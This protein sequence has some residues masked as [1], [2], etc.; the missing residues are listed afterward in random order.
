M[1][2]PRPYLLA[3]AIA[4]RRLER[5]LRKSPEEM[6]GEQDLLLANALSA[7]RHAPFWRDRLDAGSA[8]ITHK[9]EWRE[10]PEADRV[11]APPPR[12]IRTIHTSGSTGEPIRVLYPPRGAWLQGVLHL[13]MVHHQGVAPWNPR[14]SASVERRDVGHGFVG[15]IRDHL[16]VTLPVGARATEMLSALRK[17][18]P[19]AISGTSQVL[20]EVGEALEGRYRPAT[21]LT[22][23]DTL[24]VDNRAA[25]RELF[26]VEPVDSYGTAECGMV[27]WQCSR[28]DLYHLNHEAVVVEVVDDNG[29]SVG[30][31]ED[32][33]VVLTSLWNPLMP[34]VRYL[35]GDTAA[36]ATRPCRCGSLLPALSHVTGRTFSWIV[37]SQGRRVSPHRLLLSIHLE[38][39]AIKG[40]GRYCMRQDTARRIRVDVVPNERG[41]AAQYAVALRDSY[42]RLLGNLDVQVRTV[43]RIETEPGAK[44]ETF[45]SEAGTVAE[46]GTSLESPGTN[47]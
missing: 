28:A 17:L 34:F 4:W 38:P 22:Y 10:S 11:T 12:G 18:K 35:I 46:T 47:E 5:N 19:R 37:D 20:V 30:P 45:H 23:G 15:L 3:T 41:F 33:N 42:R 24:T 26:G 40:V 2:R 9:G 8:P 1:K 21:V 29:S 32:G 7:A 36:W 43:E 31:D 27:A 6:R 14:A 16:T 25:L 13:R 39:R 44:F